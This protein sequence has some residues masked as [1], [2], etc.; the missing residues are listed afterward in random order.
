MTTK[1]LLALKKWSLPIVIV[2]ALILT[3]S[4]LA[5]VKGI[6]SL[7]FTFDDKIYHSLAYL[8]F[9]LLVYNYCNFKNYKNA[10]TISVIFVSTYGII[11]EVLQY[12]LTTYRTFDIYD[13]I[14]NVLGALFAAIMLRFLIKLKLK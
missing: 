7:G 8:I 12:V 10:I 9:T 4:S 5:L 3:I 13:A 2:Y 14:A 6:P 11:I 1:L